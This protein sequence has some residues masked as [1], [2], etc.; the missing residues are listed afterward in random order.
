[1]NFNWNGKWKSVL[2]WLSAYL[3]FISFVL[4]GG[5]F[6]VKRESEELQIATKYAFLVT[7]GFTAINALLSIFNYI[8][9]LTNNYYASSA[10]EFYSV[11]VAIV[12]IAKILVFATF[13]ILTLVNKDTASS[14]DVTDSTDSE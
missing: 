2:I 9:G 5:Y 11:S 7:L 6:Y 8:G 13:I 14:A 3:N 4:V 12:G 10:Y 1:M